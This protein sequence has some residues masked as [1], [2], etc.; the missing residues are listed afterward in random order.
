ARPLFIGHYWCEGVPALVTPNIACLDYSAVKYGKLASYRF[1][2]ESR[3]DAR[4]FVWI[5]VDRDE[6]N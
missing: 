4:N 3:L 6:N 5:S 2:G 1:N